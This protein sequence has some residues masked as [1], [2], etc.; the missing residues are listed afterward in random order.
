METEKSTP[1]KSIAS[2]VVACLIVMSTIALTASIL[3]SVFASA[4]DDQ[5]DQDCL[6][7]SD[8]NGKDNSGNEHDGHNPGNP[9]DPGTPK[10]NPHDRCVGS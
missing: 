3:Q 2:V 1:R 6:P 10:G 8:N 7:R 9:H 5:K 4:V